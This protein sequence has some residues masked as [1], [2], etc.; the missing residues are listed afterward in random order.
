MSVRTLSQRKLSAEVYN[1]LKLS[2]RGSVFLDGTGDYLTVP[3]GYLPSIGTGDF[4]IEGWFNI[5]S[6][7]TQGGIFRRLWSFGSNVGLN[8]NTSAQL[9]YRVNDAAVI[10]TSAITLSQW[11]HVAIVKS[12]GVTTLYVGGVSA[13]TY[14]TN[15]NLSTRSGNT[16]FVGGHTNGNGNLQGF[17]SNFRI[18]TNAV[19]SSTFTVPTSALTPISGTTLLTCRNPT[20]IVDASINAF[21][22]TTFGNAAASSTNPFA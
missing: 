6:A 14:S 7:A 5:Q 10:T 16:L 12:S 1:K 19:Y 9:E 17:I 8:I 15:D 20:S 2:A 13:G 21:T 3:S 18:T 4:T 11:Y 22:I